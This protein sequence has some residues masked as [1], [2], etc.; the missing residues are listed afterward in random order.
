[1]IPVAVT[2]DLMVSRIGPKWYISNINGAIVPIRLQTKKNLRKRLKPMPLR[3]PSFQFLL[4]IEM[5][6]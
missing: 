4:K 5:L 6:L 3:N 2:I 1:M